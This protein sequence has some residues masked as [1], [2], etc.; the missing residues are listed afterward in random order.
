MPGTIVLV[1][2]ELSGHGDENG[3]SF[4]IGYA[5]SVLN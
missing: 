4:S 3:V 1:P 5:P 2:I